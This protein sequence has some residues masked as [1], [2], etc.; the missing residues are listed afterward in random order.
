[1]KTD[2][3]FLEGLSKFSSKEK[4]EIRAIIKRTAD[5]TAKILG[6]KNP[7]V[8]TVY[9][10]GKIVNPYTMA[11]DWIRVILPKGKFDKRELE[12]S[13]YHE[14]NH[15]ARGYSEIENYKNGIT[16]L[17]ALIAE[18]L[19]THFEMEQVQ[20]IKYP[21]GTYEQKELRKKF[22]SLKNNLNNKEYNHFEWFFGMGDK[23]NQ[24]GYKMGKYIIDELQ[25][26]KKYT[27]RSLVKMPSSKIFK[28]SGIKL[29]K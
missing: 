2:I 15:V 16:L 8:F 1:M 11:K 10:E 21:H 25:K 18:G 5:R 19:A 7:V 20:G 12:A 22:K 28:L 3:F 14:L 17:D 27:A 9:K 29:S 26:K 24:F 4:N 6:I 23:P 13:I